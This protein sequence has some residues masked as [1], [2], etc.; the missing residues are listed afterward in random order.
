MSSIPHYQSFRGIK[1]ILLI[2]LKHIG[3]VLLATPCIRS[4]HT[5]FPDVQ[6]SMLVNEECESVLKNHPLLKE[7]LIFPR[8]TLST[9]SLARVQGEI[10]FLKALR[11]RHFD[12]VVDLTSGDRAAWF[13]YLSGAR[14]RLAYDPQRKGFLGKKFL[15]NY[16]VPYPSDPD[17]HEVKKNLGV[18]EYFGITNSSPRMEL[19]PSEN[20][21]SIIQTTLSQLGL[22]A[23]KPFAVAHPTSRWL[24]KCWENERFAK[25]I[26]WL[27]KQHQIPVVVTCSSNEQELERAQTILG[28]CSTA[29]KALLGKLELIQWAALVQKACLFI[30]VDSA[31]M[32]IAASQNVPTIALFGPTGFQNWRPWGTSHT[33]LV[34]DC[35]CSRDRQPL[36]DWNRTRACMLSI[37]LEE[38]QAAVDSIL[39][40]K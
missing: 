13:S 29:P 36:C 10:A 40:K 8:S 21:L 17:L 30:G 14:Y 25:L 26:D 32:H 28:L 37:T 6:I 39:Q 20:D 34:Y 18:L 22:N 12:M 33:V 19:H 16:L 3:D 38:V 9:C 4:L 2:K 27:Q 1:Q 15:Y 35:P 24:F 11:Q 23:E 5:A 7:I 31:P